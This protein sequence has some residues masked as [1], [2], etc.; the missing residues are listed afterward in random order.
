MIPRRGVLRRV[1]DKTGSGANNT[2]NDLAVLWPPG[3]APILVM[4]YDVEARAPEDERNAVLAEVGRLA[5]SP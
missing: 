5:A 3:R 4:A 1:G 2:T